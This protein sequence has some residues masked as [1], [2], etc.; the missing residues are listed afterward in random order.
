MASKDTGKTPVEPEVAI[1]RIP[2]TLT[3]RNVKSLEKVCADVIRGAKEKNLKVK[4]PALR[5]ITRKT[6]RG[7][8]SK[9]WDC[10][11][12]RIH[13]RRTDL[14]NPSEIVKQVTSINMD[15]HCRCLSQLFWLGAVAHAC[16]L[17]TLGGQGRMITRSRV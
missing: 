12:T 13:K 11:Q 15:H 1:H 2:I 4:G 9:T 10:F 8:G 6:P 7:E 14:H 16:N 5:I 17:N 3:S